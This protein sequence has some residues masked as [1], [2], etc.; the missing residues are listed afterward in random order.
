MEMILCPLANHVAYESIITR[1]EICSASPILFRIW[2]GCSG[3]FIVLLTDICRV[4]KLVAH[5]ALFSNG[6]TRE[7]VVSVKVADC[8]SPRN[9]AT[10]LI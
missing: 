6:L 5:N 2:N 1:T 9:I 10:N 8:G 4:A 7:W 3:V